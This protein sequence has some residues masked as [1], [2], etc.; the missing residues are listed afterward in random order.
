LK[1]FNELQQGWRARVSRLRRSIAQGQRLQAQG[2]VLVHCFGC[3][4][5]KRGV[6]S[7][8]DELGEP[9][10]ATTLAADAGR[11]SPRS[12]RVMREAG[13]AAALSVL[14]LEAT[15]VLIAGRQVARWQ[16]LSEEDDSRLSQQSNALPCGKCIA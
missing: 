4:D 7:G 3:N 5:A 15:V 2:R 14:D 12:A 6:G 9:P 8:S 11:A 13:W 10:P 1:A 16:A